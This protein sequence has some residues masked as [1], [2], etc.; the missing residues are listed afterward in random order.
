MRKCRV[1]YRPKKSTYLSN[2]C[3]YV[4]C[5]ADYS[6]CNLLILQLTDECG[7]VDINLKALKDYFGDGI[8]K[9]PLLDMAFG[10]CMSCR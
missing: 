5:I 4:V 8:D 7:L 9:V 3:L 6:V 1:A 10:L 2:I